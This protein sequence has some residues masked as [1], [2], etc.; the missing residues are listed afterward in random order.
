MK[1]HAEVQ[2]GVVIWM[3]SVGRSIMAACGRRGLYV[4]QQLSKVI[5]KCLSMP[6]RMVAPGM[7]GLVKQQLG[8][9]IWV[10]SSTLMRMV[11]PGK[12]R[13]VSELSQNQFESG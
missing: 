11:A 4:K 3:C 5:V 10:C 2:L 8:V 7:R 12:R 9:V 13:L 1:G 6:M